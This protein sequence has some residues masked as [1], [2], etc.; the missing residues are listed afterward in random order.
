MVLI[1]TAGW[2]SPDWESAVYPPR[3]SATDRLR[4][5]AEL[6]EVWGQIR[7]MSGQAPKTFAIFNNHKD[8]KAFSN[9]LQLKLRAEPGAVVRGPV[10]LLHRFPELR[11]H[12][13]ASGEEQLALV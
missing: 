12:V 11:G 4:A 2:S 6:E 7:Q 13:Q 5:V 10:A 1:G 9:A 8:A 3:A